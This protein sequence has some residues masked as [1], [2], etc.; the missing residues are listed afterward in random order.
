M[1]DLTTIDGLQLCFDPSAISAVA[2]HDA[3]T[4]QAVTT[5]Y[6]LTAGRLR[7]AES[8]DALLNRVAAAKN[9]ARLTRLDGTFIWVNCIAL[10]VIRS[11]LPGEYAD[12]AKTVFSIGT[13]IQAVKQ[14]LPEV[15]LAVNACGGK[16]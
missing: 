3:D 11:P 8:V 14:T 10:K 15:K 6:G 13:L 7:I 9:F 16:L 4:Q 1:A 2:D 5:V 12:G